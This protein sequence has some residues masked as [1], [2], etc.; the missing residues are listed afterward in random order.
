MNKGRV[1]ALVLTG[2]GLLFLVTGAVDLD[3]QF[4]AMRFS[5]FWRSVDYWEFGPHVKLGWWDA[6]VLSVFRI[7]VGPLFLIEGERRIREKV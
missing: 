1:F 5:E 3:A 2:L 7:A 4:M 6:Y